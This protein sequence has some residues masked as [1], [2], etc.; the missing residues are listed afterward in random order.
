MS[1]INPAYHLLLPLVDKSALGQ[2]FRPVCLTGITPE[3]FAE[4]EERA[5][6]EDS[7]FPPKQGRRNLRYWKGL[8]S[9]QILR[10][11]PD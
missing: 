9:V 1:Q 3:T 5:E 8:K 4:I 10:S 6:E 7:L 11:G 2:C